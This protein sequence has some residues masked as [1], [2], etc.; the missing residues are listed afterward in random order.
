MPHCVTY[1]AQRILSYIFRRQKTSYKRLNIS[2][3]EYDS[4][5]FSKYFMENVKEWVSCASPKVT[6]AEE[7]SFIYGS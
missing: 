5:F 4:L 7:R 6:K 3:F 2:L 1:V